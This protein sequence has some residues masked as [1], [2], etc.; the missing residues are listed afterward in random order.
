[1]ISRY[2]ELKEFID[3]SDAEIVCL[4]PSPPEHLRIIA[5]MNVL[6]IFN[7]V[8][9]KLQNDNSNIGEVR[10]LFDSLIEKFPGYPLMKR[11]LSLEEG[12]IS[13]NADFEK[14]LAKA[15]QGKK[16]NETEF[17]SIRNLIDEEP[18]EVFQENVSF[19]DLVLS[20]SKKRNMV[21]LSWIPSTSNRVER[22]FS[23]VRNIYTDYRKRISLVNLESQMFLKLNRAYWDVFTVESCI[24]KL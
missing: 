9:L 13:I 2:L 23:V 21:D 24:N 22:L 16:L 4:L 17:D 14:A 20:Q 3:Q 1:M 5:L 7:S 11:Y 10:I 8:S 15:V 6:D 12:S 18:V 19:A